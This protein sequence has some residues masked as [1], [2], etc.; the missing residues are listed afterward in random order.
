MGTEENLLQDISNVRSVRTVFNNDNSGWRDEGEREFERML[1]EVNFVVKG[2]VVR[3]RFK[4][5]DDAK[6]Y[7]WEG[8]VRGWC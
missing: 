2:R 8:G 3:R 5:V 6:I 1:S 7:G 4:S